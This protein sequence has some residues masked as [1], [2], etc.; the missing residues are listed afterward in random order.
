MQLY[1]DL[2]L[3]HAKNS[4]FE[5]LVL[6]AT[7]SATGANPLCGDAIE[8]ALRIDGDVIVEVG[9]QGEMSAITRASA[10]LMC[11]MMAGATVWEAQTRIEVAFALLTGVDSLEFDIT[12]GEFAAMR[13]LRSYPNRIKTATL[14]WAALRQA[15]LGG[16]KAIVT[17]EPFSRLVQE[18]RANGH[19]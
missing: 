4:P 19:K 10:S 13:I 1:Q 15:L 3:K 11:G 14:P 2:I 9:F 5:R 12:L 17:T 7:H 16:A 18:N 8:I 6:A